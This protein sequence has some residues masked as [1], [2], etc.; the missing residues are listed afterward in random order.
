MPDGESAEIRNF[1]DLGGM[2]T[3]DAR[4]TKRGLIF[5]SAALDGLDHSQR[6][7]IA[8]LGVR[9]VVDFRSGVERGIVDILYGAPAVR[10]WHAADASTSGAPQHSV[11]AFLER[12]PDDM[13]VMQGLYRAIPLVQ[14]AGFRAL[15][16]AIASAELPLVFHCA[17]GKDRTGVAAA[18]L[19]DLLGVVRED[20]TADYLQS[21]AWFEHSRKEFLANFPDRDAILAKEDHWRTMIQVDPSFLE[22]MFD[23]I[24]KRFGGTRGYML[25]ELGMTN[26]SI[27]RIAS[28]LLE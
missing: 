9:L 23:E 12:P 20:I 15:F 10:V 16:E 26:R 5:R 6:E 19:L 7:R 28:L 13:S 27:D 8:Q 11:A 24:E 2:R 3:A 4:T 17:A 14:A 22:A 1:R 18:L 25:Q 21:A